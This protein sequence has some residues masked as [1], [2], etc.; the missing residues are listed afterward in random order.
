VDY[1]LNA[2]TKSRSGCSARTGKVVSTSGAF[3][4][5]HPGKVRPQAGL[6]PVLLVTIDEILA[7]GA[8]EPGGPVLV[9]V[10]DPP[11]GSATGGEG[12]RCRLAEPGWTNG[13][14]SG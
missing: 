9:A 4:I 1:W 8:V 12:A 3:H 5:D 13:A 2:S 7:R 6:L 11:S 10:V 14:P